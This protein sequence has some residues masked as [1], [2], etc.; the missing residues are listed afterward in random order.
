MEFDE[1][2]KILKS[3]NLED[4]SIEDLEDYIEENKQDFIKSWES[5]LIF[6]KMIS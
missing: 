4:F 5:K 6:L 1:E 3:I 2:T